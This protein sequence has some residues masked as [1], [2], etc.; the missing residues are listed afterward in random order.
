VLIANN[1]VYSK[2]GFAIRLISGK[3]DLVTVAGNVGAGG[4]F[5]SAVGFTEGYGLAVDFVNGHFGGEPPIDVFPEEGSALIA[6]GS[7]LHV[8]AYDFNGNPRHG[9]ADAGAY[10][11][12]AG[13]NPGWS[14]ARAF[15]K[16]TGRVPALGPSVDST[17][18]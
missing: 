2:T 9:V 4:I 11:F 15:K 14:L 10:L 7:R 18:N 1:A 8:T 16:L 12:R 17:A 3:T 6:D 13:G 5:G